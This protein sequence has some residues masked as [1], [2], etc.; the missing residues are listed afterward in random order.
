M[1][2][3]EH[4]AIPT[5]FVHDGIVVRR[6]WTDYNG[7]MNIAYYPLAYDQASD[8]I[9]EFIGIDSA[10]VARTGISSFTAELHI[11]YQRELRAGDPLRITSQLL[12]CDSRRLHLFQHMY[13]AGEGYLASTCEWMILIVELAARRV[14]AMPGNLSAIVERVRAA[15]AGLPRPPEVGRA[16]SLTARRPR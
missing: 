13:H 12:D 4:P 3:P 9:Y 10:A 14:T 6:E 8:R 7:H 16:I 5:P 2:G 1:S 15:H 11:T